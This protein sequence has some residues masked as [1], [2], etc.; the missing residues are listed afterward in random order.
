M[1]RHQIK[2]EI[3]I[4]EFL[5]FEFVNRSLLRPG[6]NS[7][8]TCSYK[9]RPV[10]TC[11]WYNFEMDHCWAWTLWNGFS[12]F[13]GVFQCDHDLIIID[14]HAQLVMQSFSIGWRSYFGHPISWVLAWL[15]EVIKQSSCVRQTLKIAT[16]SSK[17][18]PQSY[19]CCHA[20][21]LGSQT[22][23]LVRNVGHP[24]ILRRSWFRGTTP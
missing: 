17:I 13:I 18:N 20:V 8:T 7:V 24:S 15:H 19:S 1:I 2:Y 6:H 4:F 12:N 5:N 14:N 10:T 22:N 9:N 3:K 23:L 21:I 16:Q 11:S